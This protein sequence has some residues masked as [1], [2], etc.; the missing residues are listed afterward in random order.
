MSLNVSVRRAS[1]L[2][3]RLSPTL[4]SRTERLYVESF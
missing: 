2:T 1:V 3:V 4:V